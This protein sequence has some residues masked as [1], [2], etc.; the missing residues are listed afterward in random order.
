M[1]RCLFVTFL[2]LVSKFF[3]VRC[4]RCPPC[5]CW[6]PCGAFVGSSRQ[7]DARSFFTI[8]LFPALGGG[9]FVHVV[10]HSW[11]NVQWLALLRSSRA[12]TA[13]LAASSRTEQKR[14]QHQLAMLSAESGTRCRGA[15]R[16]LPLSRFLSLS[17]RVSVFLQRRCI[18]ILETI[19]T[20]LNFVSENRFQI[21]IF[22]NFDI[23]T[24]ELSG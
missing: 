18:N 14:T 21:S 22:Q 23:Y 8:E 24:E 11:L 15:L 9:Y 20:I 10:L 1:L 13:K 17:P 4:C 2:R 16:R 7:T 3:A 6:F 5:C 19:L 12:H